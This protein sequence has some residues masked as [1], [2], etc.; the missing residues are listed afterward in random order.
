MGQEKLTW[1]QMDLRSLSL[2]KDQVRLSV[3]NDKVLRACER[4][5]KKIK[6]I[7]KWASKYDLNDL[8]TLTCLSLLAEA[9]D[10]MGEIDKAY[11]LI[12][13]S[14][15][16]IK[17]QLSE[18]LHSK[19]FDPEM[20]RLERAKQRRIIRQKLWCLMIKSHSDYRKGNYNEGLE[21]LS[22]CELVVFNVLKDN[23]PDDP[24]KLRGTR[25]RMFYFKG[26]ILS[27]QGD[28][29]QAT[30]CFQEAQLSASE[31]LAD[32]TESFRKNR[33]ACIDAVKKL[34]HDPV[35]KSNIK[36]NID[37]PNDESIDQLREML[38][39][40]EIVYFRHCMGKLNCFG[41]ARILRS[42]GQLRQAR[43]KLRSA[44]LDLADTKNSY[45][46]DLVNLELGITL[47][48]LAGFDV[49]E[50]EEPL[51]LL[52]SCSKNFEKG[53]QKH[54][55]IR[56]LIALGGTHL[57]FATAWR[58]M[59]DREQHHAR[60][61]EAEQTA[62]KAD[63]ES[64]DFRGW[65]WR[66]KLLISRIALER[67]RSFFD[68]ENYGEAIVSLTKAD[69]NA[70]QAY[71][72]AS[73]MDSDNKEPQK[74]MEIRKG[75]IESKIALGE[76][77][78]ERARI[79]KKQMEPAPDKP[80]SRKAYSRKGRPANGL[81]GENEE[82]TA[83]LTK[84]RD[85]FEEV[86][87]TSNHIPI[88]DAVCSINLCRTYLVWD[89]FSD[90]KRELKNW[91]SYENQIENQTVRNIGKQVENQLE[92]TLQEVGSGPLIFKPD[93]TDL[94]YKALKEELLEWLIKQAEIKLRQANE[95]TSQA[96]IAKAL[97]LSSRTTIYRKNKSAS[98]K[99]K[100]RG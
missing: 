39:E 7:E 75:I 79:L 71:D 15:G 74:R 45:M 67:S 26:L 86:R 51:E 20:T 58:M 5:R 18:L 36:P 90:A 19:V 84:A 80:R 98:T 42:I 40:K 63:D 24:Y 81:D 65:Q 94:S 17:K 29:N 68:E 3:Y 85:S 28:W 48:A 12:K 66:T 32:K 60:L 11:E 14:A 70:G 56:S 77:S 52:L 43:H 96:S 49:N 35:I 76:I 37:E 92:K 87:K 46:L 21:A 69:E 23:N 97:G 88:Y 1:T 10:Q 41:S 4:L 38:I 6:P 93:L 25:A 31:R 72:A 61:L 22:I 73:I 95:S 59:N 82:Y 30:K 55:H 83:F 13:D 27:E 57:A 62:T 34:R 2:I 47:R 91:K 53:R 33:R 9:Y 16:V 44:R 78:L 64:K 50:L 8:N 99:N 100:P 89:L 54:Y